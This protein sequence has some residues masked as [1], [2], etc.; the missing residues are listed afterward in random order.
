[1]ITR[2]VLYRCASPNEK[3]SWEKANHLEA[4]TLQTHFPTTVFSNSCIYRY[5]MIIMFCIYLRIYKKIPLEIVSFHLSNVDKWPKESLKEICYYIF[6]YFHCTCTRYRSSNEE[7]QQ[8]LFLFLFSFLFLLSLP[9]LVNFH[10]ICS[11]WDASRRWQRNLFSLTLMQIRCSHSLT[12]SHTCASFLSPFI[13]PVSFFSL[14]HFQCDS[15]TSPFSIFNPF[16]S[17]KT[18]YWSKNTHSIATTW[19]ENLNI[20]FT[21]VGSF[22]TILLSFKILEPKSGFSLKGFIYIR[23]SIGFN[24]FAHFFLIN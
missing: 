5:A 9:S 20:S 8:S 14:F 12:L 2:R 22:P 11:R 16:S 4:N 7:P 23:R 15:Q 24:S 3:Y 17:I 19:W 6:L 10:P 21:S 1:M 18:Q 13:L